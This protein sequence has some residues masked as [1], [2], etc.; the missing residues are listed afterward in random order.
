[1]RI[2]RR[3]LVLSAPLLAAERSLLSRI[4]PAPVDGGYID[5]DYWVWCGSPIK[6]EDGRYHLFASRWKRELPFFAGYQVYSEIV[7]A[8]SPTPAG[9]YRFQQVVLPARGAHFWDGRMTHNPTIHFWRGRYLLFYIGSTYEGPD[10]RPEELAA[11]STKQTRESYSRI[12]IGLAISKSVKGPW[13]RLDEPVL[14]PRKGKWDAAIVTNPA[15]CVRPDGR[16]VM[17]YR[18]NTPKGLRLGIA[19]AERFDKPFRRL[20]DDPIALFSDG[21]GV[22]DPYLWWAGGHYEA[23]MKDMS[24]AITGE[25]HAGVHAMSPDAMTWRLK[26]QPKAYSRTVRWSDGRSTVQGSLERPQILFEKGRATH[27]FAATADGPG[28][29][30][31]ATKTWTMV[32]P[33]AK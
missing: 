19:G 2:T 4:R 22:E 11:G 10:P 30:H 13:Q 7:R 16:I 17:L 12:Q 6:G 15:P 33:L 23:L 1:M 27:L 20:T 28:G 3:A 29:F 26:A 14:S 8:E 21:Q 31:N 5:P 18:S 25:K 24:G 32:I 9:P